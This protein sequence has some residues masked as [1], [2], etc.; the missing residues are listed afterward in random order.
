M[1]GR[2]PWH[3]RVTHTWPLLDIISSWLALE[4]H[5]PRL[6][7]LL[8]A[9]AEISSSSSVQKNDKSDAMAWVH[10]DSPA[11]VSWGALAA[12]QGPPAG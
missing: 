9:D 4:M 6:A 1:D 12:G 5:R 2:M 8:P 3:S 7:A 10:T 11:L